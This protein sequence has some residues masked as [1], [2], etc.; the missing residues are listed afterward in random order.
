[1]AVVLVNGEPA[2]FASPDG[3][4]GPDGDPPPGTGLRLAHG[5]RVVL[6]PC[7]LVS[8]FLT[9]PLTAA[10]KHS[11][12]YAMAFGEVGLLSSVEAFTAQHGAARFEV[13]WHLRLPIT[14]PS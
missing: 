6:G 1:M 11:L 5:D 9:H 4:A 7:R 13:A 12:T 2:P 3:G 10:E 14:R 8:L